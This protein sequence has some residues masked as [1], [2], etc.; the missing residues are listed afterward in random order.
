MKKLKTIVLWALSI[1]LIFLGVIFISDS[2]ASALFFIL[3]GAICNPLLLK[4]IEIKKKLSIPLFFIFFILGFS[5]IPSGNNEI[6]ATTPSETEISTTLAESESSSIL[7]D[8]EE[9]LIESELES[10]TT[11]E[12]DVRALGNLEVHFLDVGQGLSVFIESDGHYM[13]YDGGDSNKSS[14]VVAYLRDQGVQNLDYVIASHYDSD[15][16]NG[17]IGALH[18]FGVNTVIGPDYVHDS[19]LYQ[20]FIDTVSEKGKNVDHPPV[21]T[22]YSLG[23][24]K[25]IILSPNYTTSDSNNNSVS[26]KIV[27]GS[28]SFILTGDAESSSESSMCNS[29]IDIDCDILCIGHHGSASSTSWEFLQYTVPEYAV[30]SCGSDNQYGHP[31]KDT[32]DKLQ[33]M[34][35]SVFRTDKQGTIIATSDGGNI[36]WNADP[37]NDYSPG[38]DNDFGTVS[39]ADPEAEP[40]PEQPEVSQEVYDDMVWIP[41]TGEKYHSIP[42]CGRMNPDK[43]RQISRSDAESRGYEA[44]QKC[45]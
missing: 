17:V 42:N 28:N 38:D 22:E 44:C 8:S 18:A 29:G 21:G 5:F 33:S 24:S 34:E 9:T 12:S 31:D 10:E 27:N 37:C 20:S 11:V 43:A 32:M 30:I 35:I 4:N 41:A 45:W 1:M 19:K 3:S 26:I 25:F 16:L 14:F 7:I 13:L 6:S 40:S 23:N 15:H 39:Q 2:I 36:S